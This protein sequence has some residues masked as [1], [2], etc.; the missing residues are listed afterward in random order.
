MTRPK[1]PAAAAAPA[2]ADPKAPPARLQMADIARFAGV[3]TATVSRALSN[4]PLVNEATRQRILELARSVQYTVN[5]SAQSLR[6]G[7]NNT[8]AVV[9]PY[10]AQSRQNLSD[11]FFLGIIGCIANSLTERGLE[12]LLSRVDEN[13]LESFARLHATGR[14][15]GI[16]VI[17]QWHHH[18]QLNELAVGRLPFVVWGAQMPG[19]LY[20]TVGSD[21]VAGGHAATAHLLAAGRRRIAFLGDTSLPEVAQ[22]FDGYL[23]A[24]REAG[25]EPEP[26]LQVPVPFLA[27]GA[28]DM[29][30]AL[31]AGRRPFDAV[32]AA[33]DL[34]A[35]TAIS[36]LVG[37]GRKVPRDVAVVGYDDVELSRHFHPPLTTVRQPLDEAGE[38]LV[39][40]VLRLSQGERVPSCLLSTALVLRES[41]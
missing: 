4:S 26:Q 24:H 15:R 41:A 7:E 13:E 33:S 34:L 32:F 21:N 2:D 29:I 12:M 36:V 27:E 6:L 40:M 8:V 16:I 9:L 11:P 30:V 19:Q 25:V 5:V 23:Q 10:S 39:E 14:A 22:R 38:R 3:S 28:R 31:C 1:K 17:G 20:C 35:M 37:R 18:D